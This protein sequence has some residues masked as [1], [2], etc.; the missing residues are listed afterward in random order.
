LAESPLAE[1]PQQAPR[2][3]SVTARKYRVTVLTPTLAGDGQKLSPIDYMVWKDQVNVLNQRRIFRLLAGGPRIESYL[4]QLRKSEKL[5]FASWG[6]YAQNYAVR[7]IALDDPDATQ[8]YNRTPAE[9]CFIPTFSS[10]LSGG[11]YLPAT[12]LKGAIRL[13][14]LSERASDGQIKLAVDGLNSEFP[15]RTAGQLESAVLGNSA[16]TRTRAILISDSRPVTKSVTR[17]YVVR[18]A[19]LI[20]RGGKIE[21]GWKTAPRGAVSLSRVADSKALFSEMA[22]P[23]SVFEG[24]FRQPVLFRNAEANRTLHGKAPGPAE[25]ARAM[26][27]AAGLLLDAHKRFAET[28]GLTQISA[29]CDALL[30]RVEEAQNAGRFLAC[31]GWGTGLLSKTIWAAATEERMRAGLREV[32]GY[33]SALRTGLPFPKTR[34][35]VVRQGRAVSMPGWI[36]IEL[37]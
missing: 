8:I 2:E 36:E 26:N 27:R 10:A 6:G 29:L 17:V 13:G 12:V 21:A 33:D 32:P 14:L 9:E 3:A 4:G 18:V 25:I 37:Y 23:G 11:F 15:R 31:V 35:L 1:N 5:D 28:A 19:T 22:E 34:H 7:R 30:K 24:D 20:E 16:T